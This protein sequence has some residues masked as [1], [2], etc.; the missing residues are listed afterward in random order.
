VTGR[1]PITAPDQR[2]Q[3]YGAASPNDGFSQVRQSV[4]S[5][6]MVEIVGAIYRNAAIDQL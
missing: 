1:P 2:K 3:R 6:S 4:G 5:N